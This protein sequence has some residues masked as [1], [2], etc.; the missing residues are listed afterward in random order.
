[1]KVSFFLVDKAHFN[2]QLSVSCPVDPILNSW[3][4]WIPKQKLFLVQNKS[5]KESTRQRALAPRRPRSSSMSS[6]KKTLEP[7]LPGAPGAAGRVLKAPGLSSSSSQSPP[8]TVRRGRDACQHPQLLVMSSH[9]LPFLKTVLFSL[10]F[11]LL[12][13]ASEIS[14]LIF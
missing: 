6:S 5:E 2:R 9:C 11:P 4:V 13:L 14:Q 3:S 7:P 10:V 8:S 1:M 12:L